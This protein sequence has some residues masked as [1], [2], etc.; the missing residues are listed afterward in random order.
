MVTK[1]RL[2]TGSNAVLCRGH[3]MLPSQLSMHKIRNIENKGTAE[4]KMSRDP[5]TPH[6][7]PSMSIYALTDTILL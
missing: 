3:I 6:T 1:K 4:T 2:E 7:P 5:P